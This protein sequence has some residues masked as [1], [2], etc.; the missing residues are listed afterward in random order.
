VFLNYCFSAWSSK[1]T[2]STLGI[3]P[4]TPEPPRLSKATVRSLVLSWAKL[5]PDVT[6]YTLEMSSVPPSSGFRPV[7]EG[8]D[9]QYTVKNLHKNSSYKFRVSSVANKNLTFADKH[10]SKFSILS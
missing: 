2:F 3:V 1:I 10:K 8:P 7:Y 4:S 6:G 5:G 9:V